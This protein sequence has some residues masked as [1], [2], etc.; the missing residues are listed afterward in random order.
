MDTTD[1]DIM[2]NEQGQC[3]HCESY[4]RDITNL[5]KFQSNNNELLKTMLDNIRSKGRGNPYDCIIGLSGGVDSTY[6]AYLV[7]KEFGLRPLAIHMDN[8]WNSELSVKN[9]EN[10]VKILDIDL[11]TNVLDWE[12]F[13]NLQLAFLKASTPDAEIPTDHAIAATL[14]KTASQYNIKYLISGAN[15]ITERI[16][17]MAWSQG[18]YDWTYIKSVYQLMHKKPLRYYSRLEWYKKWYIEKFKQIKFVPI[19]NYVNFE[20]TAVKEIITKELKW[21]DYG[22]KHY[23]STYTKFFQGHILPSKFGYDKRKGHLS[24]LICSGQIS[25]EEA[26]A[27]LAKP[28]ID[29][30]ELEYLIDYVCKKFSIRKAEFDSMMLQPS[31]TYHDYP[32]FYNSWWYKLLIKYVRPIYRMTVK[33]FITAA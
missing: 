29:P 11:I 32:N 31:K 13:K 16:M 9:V 19:L 33:R 2:F 8:G 15:Y 17:P 10:I 30:S 3:H 26:L 24:N 23:E 28:P 20:Q 25:R 5:P 14:Y 1:P 4:L 6:V 22:G 12:E 7:K 21:V 27:I 18:H